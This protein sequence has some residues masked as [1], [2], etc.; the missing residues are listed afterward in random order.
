MPVTK[1]A[2]KK[3]RKDRKRQIQNQKI[4]TTLEKFIRDTKKSPSVKKVQEAFSLIDKASKKNIIHKNKAGRLKS[5]LSK[6]IGKGSRKTS[7]KNLKTSG[8]KSRTAKK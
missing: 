2:K 7:E 8:R 4:E 5:S 3:L 1:S 6:L